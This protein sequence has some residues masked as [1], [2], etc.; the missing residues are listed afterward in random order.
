MKTRVRTFLLTFLATALISVTAFSQTATIA[1][2]QDDYPPGR[3]VIIT[4][5]GW[6]PGET[7]TLQVLHADPTFDNSEPAH[8][9][10]TV[11]ADE[12]GNVSTSWYIPTD[13]DMLG[14]T[15][16]LTA[17][18]ESSG[19]RAE[20]TFTDAIP[21]ITGIA[22]AAS[23]STNGGYTLTVTASATN[24]FPTGGAPYT[25]TI[26]GVAGTSL[27]R[28]DGSHISFTVPAHAAGAVNI[29]IL[30]KNNNAAAQSPLQFTYT[31]PTITSTITKTSYNGSDLSCN[32]STDGVITITAPTGGTATYQYSKNNGSTF[33]AS[34]V[35]S[36]LAAGTYQV[37]LKD[38]NGCTSSASSVTITAP[39]VVTIGSAVKTSYNGADLSCATSIDGK[40]TV[41]ASGGSGTLQYSKNNGSTYQAGN[42]FSGL[43][44]GTY[45]IVVKDANGCTSSATSVT[46]T[47]PT[48]VTIGSAVKTSYNGADLSCA[49]S[50]DGKITVTASGGTGTLQ[51][52]KDNGSNYQPGNEFSGLGAGT[53]Q[54]VVKD[55]NGC[56]SSATSV[57]ITAPTAVSIGSAVKTSYNGADLSCATSTDGKITVTA[58]GGTGT[59]QYSK[60][61]GSN[62]Q[63]GNEFSGLGAGTYQIV[64]KDANGCTSSATSV[65]ITAPTAV[66][67]G[68]AVK[69]SYNGA[70]LS[71]ATSTDGKITVT[72]S[73]GTGTLQYSKDNGSNY[74][75][76]NE[77][78]SL[79]A[80]TYQIVVKDANGCTSS[81]TSVTIT[82]P[83]AV[84]IGS[85]VKTSYNGA[86][87]SCATSTDGKITVTASGGTGTL[88]YSDDN[89]S[90]YQPG[91][92]FSGLGAGTYQVVVK[93]ANGCTSSAT[94]VT[95]TAPTAV[96][97]G[98]AVKTSYNGADLSCATSTDG[99]IT[100]TASGGTGALQYS[101][102]NGSNYQPGNE[103]SGL[104]AGTYQIV[105]KD[106]NGCTSSAT[107]VTITAP[108]AVTIGS[109]VKDA[110]NGA[111]LS[112]ATSTDGKITVTASGGTGALQYSKDNGTTY[113]PGNEFSG[114]GAGTYQ[115]VVK[116]ANGC[117]SPATS[118]TITAPTA[119]TIGSAVK[120]AY[121]GADLSCA[122]STDGKI[123]V[124]ASGGTGTLQYSKDNGS[125]YQAGNV[126][127][128]LGAGTY[129]IVVKDA[130]GCASTPT[131][132]TIT[133]PAAVSI[134]SAVK[135]SY[136]GADLSCATSTDGKITV[137]A[138][139][140]TG[141]L[142]Y[143]DDNGSTYQGGNVF[144]SLAA[145]TYKI[146]VKDVNGCTSA[147]TSVTI[148]APAALVATCSNNNNALYFGYS[149]DQSSTVTVT[150]SGG[151][152][153]YKVTIT[154]SRPMLCNQINDA[155]DE[156]WTASGGT[157]INNSCPANPGLATLV[158]SS[159]NTISSG[160]YSTTVSL[161]ADAVL[162]STITDAN[163]CVATCT[164]TIQAEDVRCF[165]GNSGVAKVTLCH[166]TGSSKNPC[167]SICVDP[168]AVQ[169]H[170]DHGDF[171]GKCTANCL[172]PAARAV[173]T[174]G[175]MGGQSAVIG[176]TAPGRQVMTADVMPNPTAT[177]FS[178]RVQSSSME[179]VV[180]RVFDM[181]GRQVELLR[182]SAGGAFQFGSRLKPGMYI[183]EVH[184]GDYARVLRVIKI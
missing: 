39:A 125:T 45:Q 122:T 169:E 123:T 141:T 85:A 44:A 167:V 77:F 88:E 65:T 181:A 9:P 139:G 126:F 97:I 4:G 179:A 54:I 86:D 180:V 115:I 182:G 137:T 24:A 117:T 101:K 173:T 59:L 79:G 130:N 142:Q 124:T 2:D 102:D 40:I 10:W 83:T 144:S 135:A 69:T 8:D 127:S 62:Y 119:V 15:L 160:S 116:D 60:D 50:T 149:G 13:A 20:V 99:K 28:I 98:S 107:S 151:V 148:T 168:S 105:V 91:N 171:Y 43:G 6:Q 63:P 166:K 36:G 21:T 31:C 41:T 104:G 150:P 176:S 128:G 73:G 178:L 38:A 12:F 32:T 146:V 3:T 120:D 155:G 68:S 64:V 82:A 163:G 164:T 26:G 90:T 103:F 143:S 42:A 112:C 5:T 118:V 93:D 18:G 70:D 152:G 29:I 153:P 14:A 76:G 140:G 47:A 78:S 100:V 165:A 121:N 129:K 1:T 111:D 108:T 94:S 95:I 16:I 61:N 52:S 157:T 71:C 109:A 81:A 57:T 133:A 175:I 33:Q 156:S 37:V 23:G 89:G 131:S 19:L 74:Q 106:A 174:P 17:I 92:E 113:K 7:V 75:P 66:S 136:H 49:T 154:M 134:G 30:D 87:L 138:S 158:P 84:T 132:V 22:P 48:A 46:I 27:L 55:A 25:V 11:S 114:L 58:S 51:Y 96:S 110:Y 72:A 172:P 161:M 34:N 56:T 162:T 184:Q 67:I 159:T 145:G 53:Y 35:F 147:A 80:G 183:V 177:H 170:L